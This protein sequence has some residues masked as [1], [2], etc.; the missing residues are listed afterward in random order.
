[1]YQAE[2]PPDINVTTFIPGQKKHWYKCI[3]PLSLSSPDFFNNVTSHT[4]RERCCFFT[5]AA[6]S[7]PHPTPTTGH[8]FFLTLSLTFSPPSGLSP[9]LQIRAGQHECAAA[10]AWPAK[11]E[12]GRPRPRRGRPRRQT[13]GAR[14]G[15]GQ[16]RAGAVEA[17]RARRPGRPARRRGARAGGGLPARWWCVAR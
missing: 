7:L 10:E 9:Q 14:G 15:R 4:H 3:S 12:H 5:T 13:P 17:R 16:A 8:S 1:L 11:R 2:P 6:L